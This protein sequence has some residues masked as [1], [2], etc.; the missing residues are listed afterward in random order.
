VKLLY[1]V[2]CHDIVR[3]F[4]EKRFCKCGKSWGNYLEDRMTTVQTYPSLSL[5]IANPDFTA[6]EAAWGR[7]PNSWSPGIMMRCWVNP[8]SEADVKFVVGVP[9]EGADYPAATRA[10]ESEAP[11][12]A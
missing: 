3:L 12:Q 4:P 6:A 11:S 1:C 8:A 10:S 5:G 2:H 7:D 9:A